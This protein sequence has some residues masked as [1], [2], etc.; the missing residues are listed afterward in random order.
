MKV[1]LEVDA[2]ESALRQA[3]LNVLKAT[4]EYPANPDIKAKKLTLDIIFFCTAVED[5]AIPFWEIWPVVLTIASRI[6]P[7]HEWQTRLS[8]S[9][10]NLRNPE[11][12][13]SGD[14][15]TPHEQKSKLNVIILC[16]YYYDAGTNTH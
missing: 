8:L 1:S 3:I 4:L 15:T 10:E 7:G 14:D 9:L 11:S 13:I 6:P 16:S 2:D 12:F 5:N